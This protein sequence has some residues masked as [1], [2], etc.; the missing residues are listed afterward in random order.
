MKA[1]LFAWL[2]S[3]TVA[4]LLAGTIYLDRGRLYFLTTGTGV[5]VREI[6]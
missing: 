5:W 3:M 1:C 6:Q 4:V 2:V